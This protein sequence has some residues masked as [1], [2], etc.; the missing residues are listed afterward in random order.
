MLFQYQWAGNSLINTGLL[1][2]PDMV[3]KPNEQFR[4]L[5]LPPDPAP[6]MNARPENYVIDETDWLTAGDRG[7][8]GA[9][10]NTQGGVKLVTQPS[11]TEAETESTN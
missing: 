8:N 2:Q 9:I 10:L 11:A 6:L 5:V 7:G 3:D 1:V 4:T